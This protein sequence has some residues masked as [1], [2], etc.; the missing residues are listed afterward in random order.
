MTDNYGFGRKP[1]LATQTA[2]FD[3]V[4]RGPVMLDPT[5]EEAALQRGEAL[6][7]VNREAVEL[8]TDQTRPVR[9]R[10][11]AAP[12]STV[13]IKGPKEV[14]DWFIEYTNRG[15]YPAYWHGIAE[16][17]RLH[18]AREAGISDIG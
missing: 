2:N 14:I 13:F 1:P 11:V 4:P 16:L 5:A 7:F 8:Q 9:R 10:R 18:E 17:K 6:G 3:H 12:I 15:G